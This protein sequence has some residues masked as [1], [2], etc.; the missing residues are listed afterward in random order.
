MFPQDRAAFCRG[1][2]CWLSKVLSPAE[3]RTVFSHKDAPVG[4]YCLVQNYR[5][6]RVKFRATIEYQSRAHPQ[7]QNLEKEYEEEQGSDAEVFGPMELDDE[8]REVVEE[9]LDS[10]TF[11]PSEVDDE[12]NDGPSIE[13]EDMSPS[14][15]YVSLLCQFEG[16]S[17]YESS[18]DISPSTQCFSVLSDEE[19]RGNLDEVDMR[20]STQYVSLLSQFEDKGPTS[21]QSG[22]FKVY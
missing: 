17:A 11:E 3:I 10:N 8:E 13:E 20:P 2:K 18:A 4:V 9:K 7:Q 19:E 14:T 22:P 16:E 12:E 21:V 5:K 6:F 1:I 15:Q